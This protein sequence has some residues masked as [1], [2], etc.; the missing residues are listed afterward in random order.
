M[1]WRCSS[2]TSLSASNEIL[3]GYTL[4]R[5][6]GVLADLERRGE[7]FDVALID[8]NH[9]ADHVRHELEALARLVEEGGLL[10]LDDVSPHYEGVQALFRDVAAS[11][12]WPFEAD[13]PRRPARRV[14]QEHYP[15]G[16]RRAARAPGRCRA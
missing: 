11:A 14:A 7:R 16:N 1:R 9:D 13:R 10:L 4:T 8:G 15:L 5:D 12:E 2:A 6:G 3:R